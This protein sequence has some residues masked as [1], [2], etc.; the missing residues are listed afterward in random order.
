MKTAI[1]AMLLVTAL[2]VLFCAHEA[3]AWTPD[4]GT[5]DDLKASRQDKQKALPEAP[6]TQKGPPAISEPLTGTPPGSLPPDQARFLAAIDAARMAYRAGANEMAQ[7]AARRERARTICLVLP[8]PEV[9]RWIGSIAKLSSNGEGKGVLSVKLADNLHVKTWNNSLSDI[10]DNTL[11]SP[12]SMVHR[13]ASGLR[14]G[15]KVMFSGGFISTPTDCY[16]E[17]SLTQHGSMTDPEFVFRFSEL[18]E[19]QF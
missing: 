14:V 4:K 2:V 5:L 8:R 19:L 6:S 18:V 15:G 13:V 10:G 17:T 1:V 3:F 9:R 12:D 7:G 16:R 11:L